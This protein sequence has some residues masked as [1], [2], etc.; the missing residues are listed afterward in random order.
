MGKER[1]HSRKALESLIQDI[2]KSQAQSRIY[3]FLLRRNGAKTEDIIKGTHLHPST[4]R[5][6][7]SKMHSKK[8]IFRK[9]QKND[10]IGKNPYT[11][12]PLAPVELI[13]RYTSELE[14]KLNNLAS[15]SMKNDGGHPKNIVKIHIINQE[16][17]P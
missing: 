9:K 4:V 2:L 6:T 7:L 15:L 17:N 3:L 1:M 12:Y 5:E 8:L 14:K 10:N 13:K 11:Y 16:G